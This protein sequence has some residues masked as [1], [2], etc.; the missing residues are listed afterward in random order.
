[1]TEYHCNTFPFNI[2]NS[3]FISLVCNYEPQG[4]N[5][6]VPRFLSNTDIH[7][8]GKETVAYP[9]HE[10]WRL[11]GVIMPSAGVTAGSSGVYCFPVLG[12][13]K[14]AEKELSKFLPSDLTRNIRHAASNS[15]ATKGNKRPSYKHGI[16]GGKR[17][18]KANKQKKLSSPS[19]PRI[20]H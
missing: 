17:H 8:S 10:R 3:E 13:S 19:V 4:P 2:K 5:H 7:S 9:F 11:F 14:K 12:P 18:P 15:P 6:W 16:T 20:P 1:M